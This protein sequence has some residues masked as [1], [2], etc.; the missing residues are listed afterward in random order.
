MNAASVLRIEKDSGNSIQD[1]G[2][3]NKGILKIKDTIEDIIMFM[4]L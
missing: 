2:H 1:G 4:N 3:G